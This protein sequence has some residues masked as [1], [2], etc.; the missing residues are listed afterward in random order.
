[1]EWAMD[2]WLMLSALLTSVLGNVVVGMKLKNV[3]KFVLTVVEAYADKVIT[4][5]EKVEIYDDFT[6]AAKDVLLVVKGLTPW[7]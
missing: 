4:D 6:A 1:M 2:N 7:R 5:K 3:K